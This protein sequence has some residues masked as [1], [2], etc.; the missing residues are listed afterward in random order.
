MTNSDF[1]TSPSKAGRGR[2][3]IKPAEFYVGVLLGHLQY[4]EKLSLQTRFCGEHVVLEHQMG[5]ERMG[6]VDDIPMT[7]TRA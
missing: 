5:R 6:Q 3:E 7:S 1:N 2:T 4:P